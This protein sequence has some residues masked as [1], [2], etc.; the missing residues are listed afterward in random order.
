M[1]LLEVI[2]GKLLLKEAQGQEQENIWVRDP[3]CRKEAIHR[4]TGKKC[5]H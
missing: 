4:D 1:L 5:V 3:C 2:S